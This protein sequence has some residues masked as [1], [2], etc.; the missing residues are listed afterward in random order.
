MKKIIFLL[1]ALTMLTAVSI[2]QYDTAD[3]KIYSAKKTVIVPLT[4]FTAGV[5]FR[6]YEYCTFTLHTRLKQDTLLIRGS[7]TPRENLSAP[8]DSSGFPIALKYWN[9][10]SVL[11]GDVKIYF[12]ML[13]STTSH[14]FMVWTPALKYVIFKINYPIQDTILIKTLFKK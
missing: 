12:S 4:F 10:D 1:L 7:N 11:T 2:A 13:D 5:G 8:T 14:Q 9:M 6:P 3:Y